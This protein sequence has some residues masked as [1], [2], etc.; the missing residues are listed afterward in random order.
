MEMDGAKIQTAAFRGRCLKGAQLP[1]Q[2]G[3]A[4]YLLEKQPSAGDDTPERWAATSKFDQMTYWNHDTVPTSADPVRRAMD[5][6]GLSV[7]VNRS[8]PPLQPHSML[9]CES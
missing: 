8:P 5:W 7:Q 3:Y 2:P 1:L 4:G 6:A 9:S